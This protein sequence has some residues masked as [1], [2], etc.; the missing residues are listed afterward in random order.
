MTQSD[1]LRNSLTNETLLRD[2][3]VVLKQLIPESVFLQLE[4]IFENSL[5]DAQVQE[6]FFTTHW[7]PNNK[8]RETV[9][10]SVVS[11]L[12]SFIQPAFNNYKIIFGYYLTKQPSELGEVTLH[13]DWTIIDETKYTGITAW[14]PLCDITNDNGAF[15]V[16]RG[17][18]MENCGVRGSNIDT[19]HI[20]IEDIQPDLIEIKMSKGDVLLFDQRLLHASMPNRSNSLRNA[21]GL[22]LIPAET[23]PVHYLKDERTGDYF[24]LQLEDDF[25]LQTNFVKSSPSNITQQ[26][27]AISKSR[28]KVLLTSSSHSFD[29]F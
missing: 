5:P 3:Y 22:V 13:R 6:A 29:K 9:S 8:Y 25:L 15:S 12:S 7:S 17:S 16:V 4:E 20:S 2:G 1:I 28:S 18:H 21:A 24:C 11:V 27:I 10:A 19:R 14:I 26:L 23:S